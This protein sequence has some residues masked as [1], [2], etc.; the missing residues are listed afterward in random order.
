M[1]LICSLLCGENKFVECR[2]WKKL[3]FRATGMAGSNV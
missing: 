2:M 3:Y 1:S